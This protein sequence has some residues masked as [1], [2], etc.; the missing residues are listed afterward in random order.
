MNDSRAATGAL[1]WIFSNHGLRHSGDT[2][3]A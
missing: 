2:W 3:A 1:P